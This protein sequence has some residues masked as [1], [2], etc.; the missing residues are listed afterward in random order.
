MKQNKSNE[1][2]E[3]YNHLGIWYRGIFKKASAIGYHE[4]NFTHSIGQ[5]DTIVNFYIR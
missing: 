4:S 3:W 2:T 5:K 1:S